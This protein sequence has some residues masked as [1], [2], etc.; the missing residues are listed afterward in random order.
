V[1]C[2]PSPGGWSLIQYNDRGR[3]ISVLGTGTPFTNGNLGDLGDAAL[4]LNLLRGTHRIVWLTPNPAAA[5]APTASPGGQRSLFSLLPLPVYL[6]AVQLCVAALLAAAW[7][8]HRLGPVVAERLPVVV[9]ASETVEGHGR[10]YQARRTRDRAAE[11]LRDATRRRLARLTGVPETP[12]AQP[13]GEPPS[14]VASPPDG[15][16]DARAV[17]ATTVAARTGRD[18]A[19]V[20]K[21]LHGPPPDSDAAL[22]SLANDLDT[23]EREVRQP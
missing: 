1:A 3:T 21:L 22:V 20:T 17:L 5:P 9:R 11:T 10:L 16:A 6:V 2:Y 12:Q 23:L 14:R 7:R 8:A 13:R 19:T 15:P 18:P 4:A